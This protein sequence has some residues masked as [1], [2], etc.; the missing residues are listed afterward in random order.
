MGLSGAVSLSFSLEYLF[1][2][3]K[4]AIRKST[5]RFIFISCVI[6]LTGCSVQQQFTVGTNLAPVESEPQQLFVFFDGTAN[7]P[8]STTNIWRLYKMVSNYGSRNTKSL[9][10]EG[11]GANS[12]ALGI[13]LGAGM[14]N[15]ILKGYDFL[16]SEY[17]NKY[18]QIFIFGFSRGAHQARSLAGLI[19]YYGL[20][21]YTTNTS[22]EEKR[23]FSK[24][25]FAA[26]RKINDLQ[27]EEEWRNWTPEGVPTAQISNSKFT[28]RSARVE[29][30]GVWDTVPGSSF[31]NYG[32]CK[33]RN[34]DRKKGE[35]YKSNS[36]P[37]IKNIVHAMAFDEK[38]ST[39]RPI[40]VCKPLNIDFT[41]V[42]ERWFPGAHADVGGGYGD[43]DGLPAISLEWMLSELEKSYTFAT[44][45]HPLLKNPFA[46]A[47]WSVNE[48]PNNLRS[49]C[50]NRMIPPLAKID[51]SVGERKEASLRIRSIKE[52]KRFD[53]VEQ[54]LDCGWIDAWSRKASSGYYLRSGSTY[55][56]E[57]VLN[58][59]L[60]DKAAEA[61]FSGWI[62][63]ED[64]MSMVYKVGQKLA[65]NNEFPL[66]T[67]V[68]DIA[69]KRFDLGALW[70]K[71]NDTS[72][73]E[74]L[75]RLNNLEEFQGQEFQ[76]TL[77][78]FLNDVNFFYGNNKG[79]FKIKISCVSDCEQ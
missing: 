8:K 9:Y 47:H 20:P 52:A 55:R 56:V 26:S 70:S 1:V 34:D 27:Y 67:L 31:K 13:G 76:D 78:V 46:T 77:Y 42:K 21:E 49:Q 63:P 60:K 3:T 6:I 29:F 41:A 35:R 36:Y 51:S 4:L 57:L 43:P 28:T 25:V 54:T 23:R 24:E 19:S 40:H 10:I 16:A 18:D 14:K 32:Y 61:D 71:R 5:L 73:N 17:K 7:D 66:F 22:S 58:E 38:R 45:P 37:P 12:N 39:F 53:R 75:L 44:K 48:W 15:R 2:I 59:P 30:V 74:F 69:G 62:N 72:K 11:V 65:R 79:S 33:E 64:K 68:G 50:E